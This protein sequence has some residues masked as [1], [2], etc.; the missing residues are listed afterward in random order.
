MLG[1]VTVL[2]MYECAIYSNKKSFVTYNTWKN[3]LLHDYYSSS[4]EARMKIWCSH[5]FFPVEKTNC[6]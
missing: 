1:I 4:M 5:I 6:I 2:P 3:F